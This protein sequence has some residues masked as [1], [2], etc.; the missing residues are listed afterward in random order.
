[1]VAA[2]VKTTPKWS[3]TRDNVRQTLRSG[4]AVESSLGFSARWNF[5]GGCL[6]RRYGGSGGRPLFTTHRSQLWVLLLLALSWG[7]ASVSGCAD[8]IPERTTCESAIT[9]EPR[10]T[11]ACAITLSGCSDGVRYE[12]H[13]SES[14][15]IECSCVRDG[16]QVKVFSA[17]TDC[18]WIGQALDACGW[19]LDVK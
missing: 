8:G 15:T 17:P 18:P 19:D 11:S 9:E 6:A 3:S 10:E 1:M 14:V 12:V 5:F 16:L 7:L 13:C 4:M 2:K